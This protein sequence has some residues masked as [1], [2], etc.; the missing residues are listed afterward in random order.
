LQRSGA[1]LVAAAMMYVPSNVLPVMTTFSVLQGG[2][3]AHTLIGGIGELWANGS[4]DLALIVFVA[5]IVI[6]MV[7]ML[8]LTLLIVSAQR[9]SVWRQRERAA[10]YRMVDAVGHWS[11]LD[12]YVVVTLGGM[13]QF[14]ALGAVEAQPGL[15]AFG[16]VVVL[17]M[18][19]AQAFDPRLIW[20]QQ[21]HGR[22]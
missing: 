11:M 7:K 20:L 19:S 21:E 3:K 10:L 4:W 18:L 1:L 13:L 16:A 2:E 9:R 8:V 15:L 17:T 12:V 6:P 5:S 14:G 22:A